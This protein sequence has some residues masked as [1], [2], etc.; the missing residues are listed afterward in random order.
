MLPDALRCVGGPSLSR[1]ASCRRGCRRCSTYAS[2]PLT[3]RT[4]TL[5]GDRPTQVRPPS[6]ASCVTGS[7]RGRLRD[8][9]ERAIS[10]MPLLVWCLPQ[11]G[12]HTN[13]ASEGFT[14]SVTILFGWRFTACAPETWPACSVCP[15]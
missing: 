1:T 14:R 6:V 11:R 2:C 9:A 4:D 15:C 12:R 7:H 8:M 10:T 3:F 5:R 13:R